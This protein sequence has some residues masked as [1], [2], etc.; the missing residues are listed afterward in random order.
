MKVNKN[1]SAI[2]R[3]R[4]TALQQMLP[5]CLC[6]RKRYQLL[7]GLLTVGKPIADWLLDK[8]SYLKCNP[9]NPQSE[10]KRI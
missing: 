4:V 7:T 6:E 3:Q 1:E 10:T 5:H 2:L 9:V 8:T